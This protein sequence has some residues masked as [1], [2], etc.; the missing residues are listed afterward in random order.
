MFNIKRFWHVEILVFT[1]SVAIGSSICCSAQ[2]ST[3]VFY[4]KGGALFN[5]K[6]YGATG[7]GIAN[8]TTAIQSAINAAVSAGGGIVYFPEG[9]YLLNGTITNSRADIVSLVG[10]GMGSEILVDSTLGLS[11]PTIANVQS[12]FH[13]AGIEH[14]RFVCT[15]QA[16]DTAIQMTDMVAGPMLVDLTIS[17]CNT[18]FDLVNSQY[19]TE[20]IVA[21]NL[22]DNYNTHF[23]HYDQNPG[24]LD[25][26]YGYGVYDGIYI[27]SEAGQDVFYLTGG[28]YL[29][30]SSFIIKG[31]F[32]PNS[33]GASIFNI[34]GASGQPCPGANYNTYNISVEGTSYSLVQASNNGCTGGATG[35]ALAA[36]SGQIYASGANGN[37][38]SQIRDENNLPYFVGTLTTTSA[39]SDTFQ[40]SGLPNPSSQCFVQPKNSQAAGIMNSTYVSSVNWATVVVSH[41]ETA[42]AIFQIWCTQ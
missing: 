5:V 38:S 32:S 14:L 2:T 23:F 28:A 33:T 39:S 22:T 42:G 1:I 12:Q 25:N 3:G 34:Q 9:S 8:D 41:A 19:W 11:I 21:I 26:S 36:G 20:R 40:G 6:A 18:A 13:S 37:S 4:D 29:Y 31:N 30:H 7:N 35:N 15:N 17:S 27:N 10:T 24:N 16:S